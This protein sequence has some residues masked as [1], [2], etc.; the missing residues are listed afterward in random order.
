[1]TSVHPLVSGAAR[2]VPLWLACGLVATVPTSM[3]ARGGGDTQLE[4]RAVEGTNAETESILIG[5]GKVM[6]KGKKNSII[7]DPALK[8]LIHI[9]HE[10]K[11]FT[12][13]RGPELETMFK[14]MYDGMA[15]LTK[16]LGDFTVEEPN[17]E[18]TVAG[19]ECRSQRLLIGKELVSDT[20]FATADRLKLPPQDAAVLRSVETLFRD[21]TASFG[22]NLPAPLSAMN[23]GQ[24]QGLPIRQTL[25]MAG[26]R[27][28]SE[29]TRITHNAVPAS[30]FEIPKGYKEEK[31]S[32]K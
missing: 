32:E 4:F 18:L 12:R 7:I 27:N 1:M 23:V 31:F 5:A 6:T 25:V 30:A 15:E 8:T 16:I 17:D 29:L 19:I 13:V 10:R 9:N 24:A 20:C 21:M 3:S 22:K 2:C 14:A 26:V 11:V 28:T